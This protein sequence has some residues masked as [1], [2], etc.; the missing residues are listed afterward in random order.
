ML[1]AA[2]IPIHTISSRVKTKSSAV[3]KGTRQGARLAGIEGLHDLLGLRII[4]Y[5][6]DQVDLVG[7][8]IEEHFAVDETYSVDKRTLLDP[9][10]F[11]YLS[12]HYVV[13]LNSARIQLPEYARYAGLK[14]E[15]QIRSILQ[16]T[17]AEIE[18]DLGYKSPD[19]I[20]QPLRRRFS[21]LAG[22]LE[23]ADEEFKSIRN[24]AIKYA[25]DVTK[26]IQGGGDAEINQE[27][28]MAFVQ[29]DSAMND[30]DTSIST[31]YGAP[32][33]SI[34]P[35]FAGARAQE[36]IRFGYKTLGDVREALEQ[37]S[38]AVSTV[39]VDWLNLPDTSGERGDC[40]RFAS[41]SG[42]IGLFYLY[43]YRV[44][45]RDGS[46]GLV[47]DELSPAT[48]EDDQVFLDMCARAA[49]RFT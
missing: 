10:R 5:F 25:E 24:A 38:A 30:L 1:L 26:R 28:I 3:T 17:W 31:Q 11:G 4:T 16:H 40:E 45:S 46:F 23:L 49:R 48:S 29:E 13:S 2:N 22:L 39:A 6:A 43:L 21:R 19:A 32:L 18:H 35:R 36:L 41:F 42:G 7:L 27:S 37:H 44:A 20:P 47:R 34:T 33:E 9:D 12:L 8:E 15:I 14:F